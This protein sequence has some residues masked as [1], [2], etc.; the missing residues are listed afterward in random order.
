MNGAPG[1]GSGRDDVVMRLAVCGGSS[2]MRGFLAA[3]GMT[4]QEWRGAMSLYGLA[5][6]VMALRPH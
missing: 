1:S 3:L 5:T 2:K 4:L 6:S